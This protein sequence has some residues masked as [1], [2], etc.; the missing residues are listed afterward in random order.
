MHPVALVYTPN[1]L[2][3]TDSSQWENTAWPSLKSS[4][5]I[6]LLYLNFIL[7]FTFIEAIYGYGN[8]ANSSAYDEKQT[9]TLPPVLLPGGCLL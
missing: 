6:Q 8:I 7:I 3:C 9:P 1:N 5:V 2:S 4:F